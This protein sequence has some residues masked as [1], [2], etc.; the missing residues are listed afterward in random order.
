MPTTIFRDEVPKLLSLGA[1]LVEVLPAKEYQEMH[2]PKAISI[3][4]KK[5]TRE[6]TA[7]L[8]KDQP[9][10]VYCYDYQ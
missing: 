2:L 3:P 5:L 6:A 9:V 10:I 7:N 8:R 1:Q 4:I